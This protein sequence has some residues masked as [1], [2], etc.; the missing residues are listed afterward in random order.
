MSAIMLAL[1]GFFSFTLMDL[2][3]KWLLQDYSL[4]QVIFF[5]GLFALIGLLVWI[6]PKRQILYT[7]QPALHLQRAFLLLIIDALAFYSYGELP[8]AEAY[9]LILTM[10]LFTAVLAMLFRYEHFDFHRLS[11][12]LLGFSGV[13]IVLSPAFG[14][15]HFA[16]L[17]ALA[18]A[19]IESFSFLMIVKHKEREHPLAFAFYGMAFM[20]LV[21]GLWPGWS[22]TEFS[23]TA[24]LISA[25]GGF[26][27]ALATAF[28]LSAFHRG[29]PST[30]SSMQ[31]SQ[32]IWGML[33]GAL[34]WNEWPAIPAIIG[35]S[36]IVVSGLL[37][38]RR[39]HKTARE[40]VESC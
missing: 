12:A 16:L 23:G 38:I 28:V 15:F 11:L 37:L 40:M 8:L 39:E 13:C 18:S 24:Y 14:N 5:N 10:P 35:G 2:S 29:S 4:V 7:R 30:I 19:I 31:Y 20:V 22:I 32:L 6:L 34:I 36:L 21:T 17:A 26:C 27:Y 25:G 3:I 33:L 1:L 9:T